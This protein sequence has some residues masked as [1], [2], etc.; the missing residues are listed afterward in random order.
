MKS[1][2]VAVFQLP[3]SV[4]VGVIQCFIEILYN[5]NLMSSLR[6]FSGSEHKIIIIITITIIAI[7]ATIILEIHL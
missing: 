6:T 7:I 5:G 2:N 1:D 3:K 4:C